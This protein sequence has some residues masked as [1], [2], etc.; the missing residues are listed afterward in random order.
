MNHPDDDTLLQF[1]LRTVGEA[2]YSALQQHLSLCEQ[3]RE[4][5]REMQ[6]EVER[7]GAIQMQIDLLELPRL[8]GP[9]RATIARWGWAA[10][11]AAGFLLGMLT[12]ALTNE[13]HPAAVPQRLVTTTVVS[14]SSGYIPCQASDV[15]TVYKH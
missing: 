1:V 9:I 15:K 11:L 12:A 13:E 10:G 6:A 14:S 3:C 5:E 2:E 7:L 4:R 8:P